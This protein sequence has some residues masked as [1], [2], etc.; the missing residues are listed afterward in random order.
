MTLEDGPTGPC[1]EGAASALLAKLQKAEE[2]HEAICERIA[3]MEL[4][5]EW[6]H[7]ADILTN[8]IRREV[9]LDLQR[10]RYRIAHAARLEAV[11][12]ELPS[13]PVTVCQH[14]LML[15]LRQERLEPPLIE[16]ETRE[17]EE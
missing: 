4:P 15:P 14:M 11:V 17:E 12:K 5:E 6:Q 9:I 1:R 16:G 10:E 8:Q 7:W 2:R 13:E 3:E